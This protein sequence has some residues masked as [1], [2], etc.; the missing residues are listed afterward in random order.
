MRP[1]STIILV[2]TCLSFP[3]AAQ[4]S[5]PA[6]VERLLTC[7][8]VYSMRSDEAREAGDEDG[9]TEFFNMG[10]ALR[11][12]AVATLEAAGYAADAVADVEMNFAQLAGFGH[13]A[14][15]GEQMLA[16]CLAAW[17]SP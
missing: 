13:G 6:G 9:A 1:F 8:S 12:Q 2:A 16:D 7:A 3:A 10:E 5:L 14:G 17:D 15:G 4:E 11:W